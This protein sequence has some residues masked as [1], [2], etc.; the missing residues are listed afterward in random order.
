MVGNVLVPDAVVFGTW[1]PDEW[2]D[3][4]SGRV[5][6]RRLP[7]ESHGELMRVTSLG[8]G[9]QGKAERRGEAQLRQDYANNNGKSLGFCQE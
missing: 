1:F 3:R 6:P 8:S 4:P 9:R 5:T 7:A 2:V